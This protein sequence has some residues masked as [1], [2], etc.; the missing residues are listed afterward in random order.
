M[1]FEDIEPL[2]AQRVKHLPA[3][4][5]TWVQSV[6]W[7]DLLEEDVATH[8]NILAW[9]IHGQRS[10]GGYRPWG[11][12]ELDTTERLHYLFIKANTYILLMGM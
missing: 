3:M 1:F 5:E 7:E 6:G 8:S 10:L 2:V 11:R 12:K 4:R 9:R